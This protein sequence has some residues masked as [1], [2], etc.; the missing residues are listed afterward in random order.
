MLEQVDE[1]C[2]YNEPETVS[3]ASL[4]MPQYGCLTV[5][6][7]SAVSRPPCTPSGAI[8]PL[9]A[10]LS[11]DH[12]TFV[13]GYILRVPLP[14]GSHRLTRHTLRTSTRPEGTGASQCP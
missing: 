8:R 3:S 7:F 1:G 12:S 9:S 13:C 6:R 5:G 2:G 10:F 4:R 11:C 14:K